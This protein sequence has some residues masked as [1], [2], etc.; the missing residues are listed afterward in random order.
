MSP[1][2]FIYIIHDSLQLKILG[3]GRWCIMLEMRF[4]LWYVIHF[5]LLFT[6]PD[7]L[8]SSDVLDFKKRTDS[9]FLGCIAGINERHHFKVVMSAYK[10]D[11]HQLKQEF[12]YC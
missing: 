6:F 12:R 1:N 8:C 5:K 4:N 10:S 3:L 11:R 2:H 9:R 7:K